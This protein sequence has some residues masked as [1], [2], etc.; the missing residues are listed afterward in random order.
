MAWF[1]GLFAFLF[2]AS[3]LGSHDWVAFQAQG[4]RG[5]LRD[6]G[7]K[8]AVKASAWG[9]WSGSVMTEDDEWVYD[10]Q[11]IPVDNN[12]RARNDPEVRMDFNS[13]IP[14]WF[15][16]VGLTLTTGA[17]VLLI[18]LVVVFLGLCA[19]CT[20]CIDGGAR[21]KLFRFGMYLYLLADLLFFFPL[22]YYYFALEEMKKG[23]EYPFEMTVGTTYGL[24]W[25]VIIM[26]FTGALLLLL[27]KH[28]PPKKSIENERLL[29][30]QV[31]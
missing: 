11:V 13:Q 28:V 20:G 22:I 7:S 25:G 1:L 6:A 26:V 5:M 4:Y 31:L 27:D 14:A 8:Q 17:I 29:V 19:C 3:S 23:S 9:L 21:I 2:M 10:A 15:G 24:G 16:G 30:Q 12:N 18:G